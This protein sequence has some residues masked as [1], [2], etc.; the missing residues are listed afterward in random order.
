MH[1]TAVSPDLESDCGCGGSSRRPPTCECAPSKICDLHSFVRP[2]YFRGQLLTDEDLQAEQDYQREKDMLR[3]RALHGWGVACGLKMECHPESHRCIT[4]GKGYA[5]D[6]CGRDI[7]L[8]RPEAFDVVAAIED[9]IPQERK[10]PC[11]PNEKNPCGD[12]ERCYYVTLA[13]DEQP[14]RPVTA[15]RNDC[16]VSSRCEPSRIHESFKLCVIEVPPSKGLWEELLAR[17]FEGTLLGDVKR[18]LGALGLDTA[19]WKPLLDGAALY[20]D[21]PGKVDPAKHDDNLRLYCNIRRE[22]FA[23]Y[24]RIEHRTRC[25]LKDILC[26][27]SFPEAPA[28]SNDNAVSQY[29]SAVVEALGALLGYVF[30]I[31]RDCYCW[32]LMPACEPCSVDE[33]VILGQVCVKDGKVTKI[34]NLT[35][36]RYVWTWPNVLHWASAL[37]VIPVLDLLIEK[38]CCGF[39][40]ERS[41]RKA[42]TTFPVLSRAVAAESFRRPRNA[43]AMAGAV[44]RGRFAGLASKLDQLA[45]DAESSLPMDEVLGWTAAQAKKKVRGDVVLEKVAHPGELPMTR[46]LFETA[47]RGVPKKLASDQRLRLYADPDGKLLGAVL[48]RN[49]PTEALVLE[50]QEQN[51]SLIKR[52]EKLEKARSK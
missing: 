16:G 43:I 45:V 8:C 30:E 46:E 48:E 12:L 35:G 39:S 23:L 51:R 2:R 40:L 52:I 47:L 25:D 14:T 6:C 11:G 18:C 49:D 32:N 34:C 5:I 13:Y 20:L 42:K 29:Q 3:N 22:L 44:A 41:A 19:P 38:L 10:D 36:R 31:Q 17:I 7:V 28:S 27:I 50:L 24:E 15:L 21:D 4:I 1:R 26:R 33:P 9:C 37:P